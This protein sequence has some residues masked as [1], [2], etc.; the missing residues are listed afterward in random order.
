[1]VAATAAAA[2]VVPA[3]AVATAEAVLVAAV[4]VL[5]A[6]FAALM[7]AAVAVVAAPA[8]A[9]AV[10]AAEAIK[11]ASPTWRL[12]TPSDQLLK[13]AFQRLQDSGLGAFLLGGINEL[14]PALC[15]AG[16]PAWL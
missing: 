7:A 6:A 8:E 1:M 15:C 3:V 9:V 10:V 4:V 14:V 12:P 16:V 2:V 5:T 13:A 11:P